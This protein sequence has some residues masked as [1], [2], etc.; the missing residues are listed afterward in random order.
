MGGFLVLRL[1]MVVACSSHQDPVADGGG[2]A[3]G[4][5]GTGAAGGTG[6]GGSEGAR[7]RCDNTHFC[8]VA[9][10]CRDLSSPGV[11]SGTNDA[12]TIN[13]QHTFSCVPFGDC[14]AR[15]CSCV[16]TNCGYFGSGGACNQLDG[17][18]TLA[19]CDQI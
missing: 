11:A 14:A 9:E 8:S 17:G 6:D 7:F 5:G 10:Y 3:G 4:T 12:G 1:S 2:G 16:P 13:T 18:G 19:T 15:D